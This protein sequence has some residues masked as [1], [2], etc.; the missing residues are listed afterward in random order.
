MILY[1][2]RGQAKVIYD[3]ILSNNH[4]LEYLVDDNPHDQFPHHLKIYK[5]SK[6]L[7]QFKKLI[8]AIGDNSI[9][10]RIYHD[11]KDW[12]EFET[13]IHS[14]A[15]VSRFSA[16]GEGTV[17][18]PQVCINAEVTIGNHCIIN[19]ASTI[20]HECVIE[21]FVHISPKAS[22]AGNI[23]VRKGVQIGLGANI[24]QGI[25]IGEN[26]VIGAGTVVLNDVPANAVMVGN[27]GRI[28]KINAV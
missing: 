3:L 1:G 27:P 10:E 21:D 12:C 6:E 4:L 2:A 26:A 17:I 18:M 7:I 8:I 19:T 15:Y 14:S 11:I 25:T 22:L 9:R 20:E 5:P 13:I 23:T 28:L 16:V 24:I